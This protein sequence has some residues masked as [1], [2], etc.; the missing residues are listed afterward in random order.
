MS[1]HIIPYR[2]SDLGRKTQ[3]V[4]TILW[5]VMMLADAAIWGVL[6]AIAFVSGWDMEYL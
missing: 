2:M 3:W 6:H 5:P 4:F 1:W